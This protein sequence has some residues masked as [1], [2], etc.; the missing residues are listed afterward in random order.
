M[1]AEDKIW[2]RNPVLEAFKQERRI[3]KL[4]VQQGEPTGSLKSI[5][6]KAK[7]KRIPITWCPKTKLDE[8]CGEENANHQGVVAHL[9]AKN[10][11]TVEEILDYARSRDEEPF[12]VILDEITDVMNVGAI[13]RSAEC[14]GV[15]G[16]IVPKR[17]SA[18][19][20]GAAAKASSGAIEFMRIAQVGNI[21]QTIDQLKKKG[22]WV[23]GAEMSGENIYSANLK[24]PMAFV[25]GAEGKGI[26]KLVKEQCD[27]LVSI[28]MKGKVKSLNASVAA[29]VVLYEKMRQE[30]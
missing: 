11:S 27:F 23:V 18:M 5:V 3:D 1:Q 19:L 17:R 6:G 12:L 28:P 2:G 21:S 26:G 15:H 16:V 24:G 10:Y 25:I 29:G 20:G 14:T 22:V 7:A 9:A 13:I 30:L 4:L 8:V